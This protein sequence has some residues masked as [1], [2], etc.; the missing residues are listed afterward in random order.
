MPKIVLYGATGYTGQL[1]AKALVEGGTRPLLAGRSA[2]KLKELAESL[3]NLEYAVVDPDDVASLAT[4]LNKGD[5]LVATVGPFVR[6]GRYALDAALRAGAHYVDSTGE[7]VFIADVFL[8]AAHEAE[9]KGCAVLTAMGYD[10][11]PGHCAAGLALEKAGSNATRVDVGYFMTESGIPSLS[12]G[13][14]VSLAEAVVRGAH[15]FKDGHI[16]KEGLGR[17]VRRFF[18]GK[19]K[20]WAMSVPGSEP[21]SLYKTYTG[22][23]E[24]NGFNGWF[25]SL[26]VVFS[27]YLRLTA[28]LLKL[29]LYG[30]LLE[31]LTGL[32]TSSGK[33]ADTG[34]GSYIVACAHNAGGA[35]IAR[36]SLGGV[37]GYVYTGKMLAWT[38]EAILHGKLKK[39]GALGPIEAFGLDVFVEGNRRCG[40]NPGP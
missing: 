23:V 30:R 9:S 33:G 28:L 3:G 21:F 12:Q 4:L 13:T 37:N 17:H 10:Y 32:L 14:F 36:A 26:S 31:F 40:L 1:T 25:G 24:I 8:N 39:T 20:R 29:P 16:Q 5:I 38:A 19:R 18:D 7:P 6:Y 11:A 34:S 2:G 27:G 22:L 15:T 35:E